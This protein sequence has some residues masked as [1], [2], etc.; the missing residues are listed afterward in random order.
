MQEKPD[1][2]DLERLIRQLI[3]SGQIDP[4]AMEQISGLMS[5]PGM[6]ASMFSNLQSMFSSSTDSVNWDLAL[7]QG[8][9]LAKSVEAE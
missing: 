9:T 7:G 5:N 4:K 1:P 8:V 3:E 2:N 6:L